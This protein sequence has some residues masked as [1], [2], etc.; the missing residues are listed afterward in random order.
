[1]HPM[2]RTLHTSCLKVVLLCLKHRRTDG[3]ASVVTIA[4]HKLPRPTHLR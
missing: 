2:N 3:P 1:M 4:T